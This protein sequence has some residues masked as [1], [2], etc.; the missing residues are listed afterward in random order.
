MQSMATGLSILLLINGN[1]LPADE[2][3]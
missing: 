3:E 2:H 1:D